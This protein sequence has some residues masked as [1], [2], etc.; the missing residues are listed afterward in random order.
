MAKYR[1][2]ENFAISSM[3][4]ND[5]KGQTDR[6]VKSPP[7]A[8]MFL[9]INAATSSAVTRRTLRDIRE[10]CGSTGLG[11]FCSSSGFYV[12]VTSHADLATGIIMPIAN[13]VFPAL[14]SDGLHLISAANTPSLHTHTDPKRGC[15][16]SASVCF[17]VTEGTETMD[18]SVQ[19]IAG[20]F[21]IPGRSNDPFWVFNVG[22]N[23]IKD[24]GDV[25]NPSVTDLVTR[26]IQ[27]NPRFQLLTALILQSR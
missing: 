17:K 24:H 27:N 12:S 20:R 5:S 21:E 16:L 19:R 14:T 10:K 2:E 3:P 1:M 13:F 9:Y 18:F 26:I 22:K 23:V 15:D 4:Q 8:D 6:I 11:V 25:W 7:P